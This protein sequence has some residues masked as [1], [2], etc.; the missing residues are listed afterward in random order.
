MFFA[1]AL[2]MSIDMKRCSKVGN[3]I[4]MNAKTPVV[5]EGK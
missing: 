3:T 5:S 1:A 4:Y 2:I